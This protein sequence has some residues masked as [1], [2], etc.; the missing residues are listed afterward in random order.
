MPAHKHPLTGYL[1][2]FLRDG[3]EIARRVAR[4]G[5]RAA[6]MAALVIAEL[7][8]LEIGDSMLIEETAWT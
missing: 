2:R 5:E 7:G 6:Q 3:Q 1:I 4:D 8:T